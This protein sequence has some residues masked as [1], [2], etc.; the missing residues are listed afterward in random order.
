MGNLNKLNKRPAAVS[1][2]SKHPDAPAEPATTPQNQGHGH[3]QASFH[4]L[5]AIQGLVLNF[6]K[7]NHK[8]YCM[9]SLRHPFHSPF[10]YTWNS[11][12][13]EQSL[14]LHHI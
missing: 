1:N 10:I 6:S 9:F 8:F 5:K 13:E 2:P 7:Q 14:Q 4:F 11:N 12:N 3:M